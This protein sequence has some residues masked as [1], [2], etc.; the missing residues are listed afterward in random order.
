MKYDFTYC[1]QTLIFLRPSPKLWIVIASSQRQWKHCQPL[2]PN[3]S[4]QQHAPYVFPCS[5]NLNPIFL[6]N[7]KLFVSS[8][9]IV[10]STF[11]A[12]E[13]FYFSFPNS[14]QPRPKVTPWA[15][16][17]WRTL[18]TTLNVRWQV[19]ASNTTALCLQDDKHPHAGLSVLA[20]IQT[21]HHP[22]TRLLSTELM[23]LV[24]VNSCS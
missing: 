24:K 7:E 15:K 3:R 8:C 11:V 13:F 5:Y 4:V 12:S 9:P 18:T 16:V 17:M 23:W 2:V 1:P 19:T 14:E 20:E 10:P 21:K 6:W 22:N